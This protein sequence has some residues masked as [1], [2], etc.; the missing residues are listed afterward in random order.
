MEGN[1]G[2]KETEKT[3]YLS[4]K[5][6]IYRK[7]LD[8]FVKNGYDATSMSMIAKTLGISKANL[9]YYCSNKENLLYEIHLDFLQTHFN[10]IL[11]EAEK[12][13]DPKERLDFV[14]RKFTLM[15]TSSQA[16][17]VLVHEMRSLN[18]G[19]QDEIIAI[20]KKGYE[21]VSGAIEELQK[22]GRAVKYRRSFLTFLGVAMAFWTIYWWDYSRQLNAEELAETLVQTFFHG[23][24]E[25]STG[26]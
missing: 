23:L 17:Q 21:F 4:R 25:A 10:P 18:R 12:R 5:S 26:T 20:W 22:S 8:L 6:E 19:H 2:E 9:Y 16:S 3:K 11:A 13:L 1:Q 24:L 15:C 14:L 7:T